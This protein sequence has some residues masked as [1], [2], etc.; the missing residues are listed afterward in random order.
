VS[1]DLI[2]DVRPSDINIAL[3]ENNQLV[4]LHQERSDLAFAVGNIYLG[5]VKKVMPGLNA[6]FVDIGYE[7]DAFLHYQDMGPQF[8]SLQKFLQTCMSQKGQTPSLQK[9]RNE[10]DIDKRGKITDLLN[11]G[12]LV[13]V[14]VV[15]EPI[16]TKGPRLSSEISFA[17]R[18]MVLI[19][20]YDKISISQKINSGEERDRLHKALQGIKSRNF[21][22]IVRT[23][24]VSQKVATLDRELRDLTRRFDLAFSNIHQGKIPKLLSGEINRTSALLRDILNASFSSIYVNDSTVFD[25]V[26]EYITSIAPERQNIIKLYD[27]QLPIFEH[28]GIEKSIKALFGKTVSIKAG[29]YLI[30]EHTEALH[31]VDVN[32]GKKSKTSAD[33]ETTALEANLAAVSEIARQLRLRDMGGIIVID[34]IDM[35]KNDHRQKVFEKMKETMSTDRAKHNILPLSK[36]GLMQI[37]R[38]RVRPEMN[39][40][41]L[42]KCPACNGTGEISPS[43]LLIDEIESRLSSVIQNHDDKTI[44]LKVHP[45]I[46]AYINKGIFSQRF[47]WGMKFSRKIKIRE[48]M[49]MHL[50][51]YRFYNKKNQEL[52]FN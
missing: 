10:P 1:K 27:E 21:G 11:N 19:P 52:K 22:L 5:R 29:S 16:S 43:I 12:Q 35:S 28:F 39:I 4:E 7:K 44:F 32:S 17:G 42:E 8:R 37:T 6:A 18:N 47:K 3:L 48:S 31:V 49:S 9:F 23:A 38:Q 20:F 26:K 25:D 40:D 30:I 2:I 46:A 34:F 50:T 15:K 41:T 13:V 51:G 24:A 14:Q 45:Y 33:Q 36:F